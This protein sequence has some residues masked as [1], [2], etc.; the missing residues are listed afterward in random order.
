MRIAVL[1]YNETSQIYEML[2]ILDLASVPTKN[3]KVVFDIEGEGIVF[4]VDEVIY[5]ENKK[6]DLNVTRVSDITD[7][8]TR[9]RK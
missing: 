5:G 7:F 4:N 2:I 6:V 9:R 3:D 1:E 8:N